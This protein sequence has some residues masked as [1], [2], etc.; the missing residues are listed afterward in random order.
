[1]QNDIIEQE[2]TI[3]RI[4]IQQVRNKKVTKIGNLPYTTIDE[5]TKFLQLLKKKLACGGSINE[6]HSLLL[7]GDK[8]HTDLVKILK[9]HFENFKIDLNGKII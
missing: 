1:M 7:Q 3:I 5:L 4:K 6:D 8:S 9:E 2:N